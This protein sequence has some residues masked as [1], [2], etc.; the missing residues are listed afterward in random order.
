VKTFTDKDKYRQQQEINSI[1][2]VGIRST[3]A[4]CSIKIKSRV[5]KINPLYIKYIDIV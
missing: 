5:T 3:G 4:F 2:E 1:L